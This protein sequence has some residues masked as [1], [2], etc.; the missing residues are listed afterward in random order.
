M[1]HE[2]V[3]EILNTSDL[4]NVRTELF[5]PLWTHQHSTGNEAEHDGNGRYNFQSQI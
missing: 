1:F 3:N 4:L 5:R 2:S